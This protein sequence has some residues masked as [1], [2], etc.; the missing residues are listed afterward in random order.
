LSL[1]CL[2]TEACVHPFQCIPLL[3]GALV[4]DD[5]HIGLGGKIQTMNLH[6]LDPKVIIYF[7]L[8]ATVSSLCGNFDIM[9]DI[10]DHLTTTVHHLE[11][12]FVT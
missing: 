1:A 8:S 4:A 11:F 10:I 7:V 3:S 12:H 6:I 5:L 9:H 2:L